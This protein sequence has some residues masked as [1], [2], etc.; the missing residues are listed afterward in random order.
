MDKTIVA[1]LTVLLSPL[2]YW[3]IKINYDRY[4]EKKTIRTLKTGLKDEIRRIREDIIARM[5]IEQYHKQG[6][7]GLFRDAKDISG[8]FTG[9]Y[10]VRKGDLGILNDSNLIYKI[11]NFYE[12]YENWKEVR[13][14]VIDSLKKDGTVRFYPKKSL[15]GKL[16]LNELDYRSS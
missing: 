4:Q 2:V 10:E 14:E 15:N 8:K 3:F 13:R 12:K 6:V 11:N 16:E 1:V 7:H 9:F 5:P